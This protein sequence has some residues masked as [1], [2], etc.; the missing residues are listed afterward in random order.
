[1]DSPRSPKSPPKL[2]RRS[3]L[4][5]LALGTASLGLAGCGVTFESGEAAGLT[6]IGK[7]AARGRPITLDLYNVFGGIDNQHWIQLA[8]R[9]E[10]SQ[11]KVGIKI[12]YSPAT[13]GGGGDNPKLLTS[14]AG[15]TAPD[16]AQ[17]TP[18]STPQWAELGVMTD[19]TPYFNKTGLKEDDF[20]PV[21]WKDM[22][23][24][25]KVWQ[26]Q[27]DADPNFPFFWNKDVF[28]MSGLD[29][30]KPPQSIQEVD[31]YS[32]KINKTENGNVT[33]IGI[34][35]WDQYGFSNS[36]FTWGWAFGGDFIDPEGKEVTPDNEYVVKALEWMVNYAKSVGGADKLAVSPPNLQLHPF[37]SGNI[38]MSSLVAP[39]YR[40][41][42][43]AKPDMKIGTGLLPYQ[44]P[45]ASGPGAGAWIG[46]WALFMPTGAKYPQAAW[47]FMNWVTAT[48]EGVRAQWETVGFPPSYKKAS[49]LEEMKNDPI[50]APYYRT[51][52][53]SQHSRPAVVVGAYFTSQLDEQVSNAVFG[54]ATPLQAM[55]TAKQNTMTEW[56]RFNR[57]HGITT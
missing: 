21:I 52:V 42:R 44:P 46:G 27:W 20:F 7:Q 36:L 26:M 57:E 41:I 45:K 29:P 9:Y 35:P 37:S 24:K 18:F 22:T 43:K 16:L 56:T 48:D 49:V 4:Q 54:K 25:D 15:D 17:L 31:E 3:F 2:T 53:T 32:K 30:N 1:M 8:K 13:G 47:D 55:R 28:E 39:N 6:S 10:A 23:Y 34:V 33:Q 11:D 5:A 12:T 14:I 19:L 38:G 50:M 51:L 40:D